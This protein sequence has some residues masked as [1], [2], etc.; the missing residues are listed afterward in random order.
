MLLRKILNSSLPFFFIIMQST[1]AASERIFKVTDSVSATD[2]GLILLELKENSAKRASLFDLDN[3]TI[4]FTPEGNKYR[5]EHLPSRFDEDIGSSGFGGNRAVQFNDFEFPFSGAKWKSIYLNRFN[6]VS[7]GQLD[8]ND[9]SAFSPLTDHINTLNLSDTPPSIAALFHEATVPSRV[10]FK[11]HS[12]K[13]VITWDISPYSLETPGW[14]IFSFIEKPEKNIFQLILFADGVIEINY[15]NIEMEE[16]I[17]GVFPKETL[18]LQISDLLGVYRLEPYNNGWHQ[19]EISLV[20]DELQWRNE[21]GVKWKLTTEN[22]KGLQLSA[23]GNPYEQGGRDTNFKLSTQNGVV[24]GFYFLGGFYALQIDGISRTSE[25]DL[26]NLELEYTASVIH[27]VFRYAGIPSMSE[28]ACSVIP[29]MGD[30]Y[31]FLVAFSQFRMDKQIAGGAMQL[32]SNSIEGIGISKFNIKSFCSDGRLSAAPTTPWYIDSS[33]GT[34]AG[35]KGLSDNYNYTLSMLGHELTHRWIANVNALVAGKTVRLRGDYCN[36]HWR[37]G[38]HVPVPHPWEETVQASRMGGGYWRDNGNGYFTQYADNFFVPASGVSYLDL[39]LMGLIPAEDVPDFF[40]I[41]NLALVS[42]SNS[43]LPVYSGSRLDISINDV[44]ALEGPR[45]PSYSNSQKD[46]NTA[47]VYLLEPGE[48]VIRERFERMAA[49]RDQW[50]KHW[51]FTTGGLSDMNA[52]LMGAE[53]EPATA[54]NYFDEASGLLRFT[55][56]AGTSGLVSLSFAI[57]ATEPSVIVQLDLSSAA[58]LT[59]TVDKIAT[60]DAGTGRLLLPE[61]VISGEVA[62]RNLS[63]I[64][65]DAEQLLFTLESFEQ[66]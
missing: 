42:N 61:L 15:K 11:E 12:N 1:A 47:F 7:F 2:S 30:N 35:P 55:V 51:S 24:I 43:D 40:L 45:T 53:E 44:I 14:E 54:P 9:Y 31:D 13:V 50:I 65:T 16:G 38:L 32:I 37:Q 46:F 27:E 29:V 41:E 57:T 4:R 33:L 10:S 5:V 8:S 17:V 49:I 36:C 23:P 63:F 25:V 21:A 28:I 66:N 62:F 52:D 48:L 22:L 34:P 6:T 19:G 20:N 64:L 56:D 58:V 26:S 18:A 3:K 60:F 39:Y 59:E